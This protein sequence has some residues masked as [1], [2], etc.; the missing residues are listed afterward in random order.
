VTPRGLLV[1]VAACSQAPAAPS[2]HVRDGALRDV[3]GRAAILR[4]L[5][6]S[7]AQKM[8]P[9]LDD[10]QPADYQ[11][12]RDA[13]GMNAIRFVMTW[14]AVEPSEGSYDDAYLDQVAE[15][16][17]WAADAGL[18]V[19]L[20]MHEDVY[21]EGFGFDGAPAWTCDATYYQAFVPQSDWNLDTFDPNVE[22]CVD[23]FYTTDRRAEFIAAWRHV[24]EHLGKVD[25]VIG[26]DVLN[27]PSWGTYSLFTFE[28]DRLEPLYRD[29]V[30]AVRGA[31][32]GWVAFLEPGA[33]RNVG[34]AT[35]L[36]PFGVR[37]VMYAPHSYDQDAETGQG[38]DPTHRQ[39]I[40]DN[41]AALAGEADMLHAGLWIGEYGGQDSEPGIVDYMTAQYDAAGAVAGSTMYW[42]Y[43]PGPGYGLVDASGN[44][45]PDLVGALVR[46][47]PARVAGDPIAYGFDAASQTFTF[48]YHPRGELAT[49][50]A[51]PDRLYPGGYTLACVDCTW[52]RAP[53]EVVIDAPPHDDPASVTIAPAAP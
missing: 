3:D 47:Y 44:E 33:T 31:A 18:A 24:A 36:V 6:V 12:I 28:H 21:G 50:I 45:K 41:V 23:A 4:G 35:S 1:L 51:V 9:Y 16:I 27:E 22:A 52:H 43:D 19:V 14:S 10:K 20:D 37:D 46:P 48:S 5:N 34:I 30:A 40:L 32:P 39:A 42:S 13:W 11:R 15:R 2:W 7:G 26:F 49:E 29:V 8:A 25:G 17:G 53:G 38:F